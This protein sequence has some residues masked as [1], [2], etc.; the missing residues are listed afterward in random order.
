MVVKQATSSNGAE[1]FL[2][3]EWL[4]KEGLLH[5]HYWLVW[6]SKGEGSNG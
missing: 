1:L 2:C 4:G 6:C 5:L 3:P